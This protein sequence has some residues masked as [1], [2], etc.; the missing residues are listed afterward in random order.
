[1][2]IFVSFIWCNSG[3]KDSWLPNLTTVPAFGV[4]QNSLFF[5]WKCFRNTP[6]SFLAS[7]SSISLFKQTFFK[8]THTVL[9][10]LW[11][12]LCCSIINNAKLYWISW[13]RRDAAT[14]ITAVYS[15]YNIFSSLWHRWVDQRAGPLAVQGTYTT[16]LNSWLMR[17]MEGRE[18][19]TREKYTFSSRGLPLRLQC[20]A[21]IRPCQQGWGKGFCNS[22]Y[23]FTT[24]RSLHVAFIYPWRCRKLL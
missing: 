15:L 3:L 10:A 17:N 22:F 1:M 9:F 23:R 18:M 7:A 12:L 20:K 4:S 19:E 5:S 6:K 2:C 14:L 8:P 24:A 13:V 21:I 16:W 11:F